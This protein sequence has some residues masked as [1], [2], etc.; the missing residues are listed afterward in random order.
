MEDFNSAEITNDMVQSI[1]LQLP[2]TGRED[3]GSTGEQDDVFFQ[4]SNNGDSPRSYNFLEVSNLSRSQ[5][6]NNNNNVSVESSN[7]DKKRPFEVKDR[8]NQGSEK[9][10]GTGDD[11]DNNSNTKS[12]LKG[13]GVRRRK[14]ARYVGGG[15]KAVK[16]PE[17]EEFPIGLENPIADILQPGERKLNT[18]QMQKFKDATEALQ[19]M[20]IHRLEPLTLYTDCQLY[21]LMASIAESWKNSGK[22]AWKKRIHKIKENARYRKQPRKKY[23]R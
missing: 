8:I 5:A 12:P 13:A 16:V 14:R 15:A 2:P 17:D 7:F 20:H 19:Q 1:L 23:A 22:T 9:E 11:S 10:T 21:D 6:I 3:Q 4:M 18:L